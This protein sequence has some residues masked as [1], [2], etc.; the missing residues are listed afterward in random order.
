MVDRIFDLYLYIDKKRYPKSTLKR[1]LTLCQ[2][3][4]FESGFIQCSEFFFLPQMYFLWCLT[5]VFCLK[6]NQIPNPLVKIL[7]VFLI[8]TDLKLKSWTDSIPAVKKWIPV[9][10][11]RIFSLFCPFPNAARGNVKW[12]WEMGLGLLS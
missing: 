4:H 2:Q 9:L 7:I 8:E 1:H 3:N 5:V 12:E 6:L 11:F 10:I